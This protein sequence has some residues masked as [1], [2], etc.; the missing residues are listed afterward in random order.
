MGRRRSISLESEVG[1]RFQFLVDVYGMEGPAYTE[2]LLPAV[3]YRRP[4]LFVSVV[5]DQGDGA[6]R[7]ILASVSLKTECGFL[8]ANVPDLVEAAA[9]A[10]RHRVGWKA[11]NAAAMLHSLD[12]NAIWL[13]RLV[14]ALFGPQ[15][16][17]LVRKANE[18][19]K[20]MAGNPKRRPPSIKWEY[21]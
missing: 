7:R 9:F 4:E 16:L 12:D 2:R 13:K 21:A 11:H 5:L 1:Q 14:S 17:D 18:R 3:H 10:P 20:D 19:P 6:G 8:T 15:S